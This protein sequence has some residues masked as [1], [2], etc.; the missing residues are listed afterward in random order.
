MCRLLATLGGLL[1]SLC[2]EMHTH[3][4]AMVHVEQFS[5]KIC[6]FNNCSSAMCVFN[7]CLLK[8]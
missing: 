7:S 2:Q 4:Q 8:K 6:A 5:S 1:T 3:N